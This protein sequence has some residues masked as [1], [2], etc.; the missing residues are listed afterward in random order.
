MQDDDLFPE[1]D[2]EVEEEAIE[3]TAF[4]LALS[5]ALVKALETMESRQW[6]EVAE[7][8]QPQLVAELVI[9]ASDA[10]NPKH[11]LKKLVKTLVGSDHVEEVFATD[12]QLREVLQSVLGS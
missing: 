6:L 11:M 4:T 8:A 1:L 12:N 2:D 9:A 10:H 7:G 5:A 3:P